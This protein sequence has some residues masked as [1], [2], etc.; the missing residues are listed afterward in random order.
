MQV[1]IN[2]DGGRAGRSCLFNS[3]LVDL[4]IRATRIEHE[5]GIDHDP[6][7]KLRQFVS[8]RIWL[9][10]AVRFRGL[11]KPH[12]TDIERAIVCFVLGL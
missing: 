7:I 5:A 1:E 12:A 11:D 3:R 10:P 4:F 2:L 6:P 9:A 8:M